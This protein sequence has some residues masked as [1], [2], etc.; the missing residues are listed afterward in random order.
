MPWK[1]EKLSRKRKR[2]DRE[3]GERQG[4]DKRGNQSDEIN[5]NVCVLSR[6]IMST[7]AI[8]LANHR[9]KHKDLAMAI[10]LARKERKCV[11]GW[12]CMC[13]TVVNA[14]ADLHILDF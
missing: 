6:N 10:K 14:H 2:R 12:V 7:W 1:K 3:D 8:L 11:C 13:K 9:S 5:E 4:E